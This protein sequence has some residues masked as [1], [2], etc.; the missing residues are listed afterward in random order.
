MILRLLPVLDTQNPNVIHS[1]NHPVNNMYVPGTGQNG[2]DKTIKDLV[3]M[4][5]DLYNRRKPGS[6]ARHYQVEE[7]I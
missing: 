4:V 2:E 3:E 1:L 5:S 6:R 7:G